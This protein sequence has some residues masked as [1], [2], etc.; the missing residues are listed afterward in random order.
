MR[1][2]EREKGVG[3]YYDELAGQS[4]EVGKCV[5][6]DDTLIKWWECGNGWKLKLI[7]VKIITLFCS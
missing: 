7:C 6:Q 3:E 2:G 5:K 4:I 1:E